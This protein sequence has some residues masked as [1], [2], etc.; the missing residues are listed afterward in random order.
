[1]SLE[2]WDIIGVPLDIHLG[3]FCMYHDINVIIQEG[4]KH[5]C[6]RSHQI[7][8]AGMST[9]GEQGVVGMVGYHM[10]SFG[11]IFLSMLPRAI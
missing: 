4:A 2:S 1:M 10:I 6:F 11:E 7:L 5:K 3:N 9:P 8:E